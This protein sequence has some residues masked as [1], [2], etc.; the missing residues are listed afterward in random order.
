MYST[1]RGLLVIQ[2]GALR[3]ANLLN[4][5]RSIIMKKLVSALLFGFI[6][7]LALPVLA[8]DEPKTAEDCK[9]MANG[10]EAKEKA[11]MDKINKK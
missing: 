1:A 9:K 3:H 5:S 6:A 11:C 2:C 10:D 7:S 8:A 4:F